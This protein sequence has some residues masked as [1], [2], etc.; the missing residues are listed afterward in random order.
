MGKIRLWIRVV[1]GV[2]AEVLG[3]VVLLF[4]I[5]YGAVHAY[6]VQVIGDEF[7]GLPRLVERGIDVT[8]TQPKRK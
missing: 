2:A 4:F 5:A 1:I 3:Y 8:F 6:N 7:F